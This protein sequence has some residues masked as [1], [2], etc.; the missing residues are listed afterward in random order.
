MKKT[1]NRYEVIC[2]YRDGSGIETVVS[3]MGKNRG[4]W[5]S[6]H[7]RSAA[8]RLA[9]QCRRGDPFNAYK[10]EPVESSR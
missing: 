8:Y 6:D 10:V 7:G 5:D 1:A 2:C 4:T 3:G 9:A